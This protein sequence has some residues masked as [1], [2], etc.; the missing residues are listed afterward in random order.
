MKNDDVDKVVCELQKSPKISRHEL[1]VLCGHAVVNRQYMNAMRKVRGRKLP[2]KPVLLTATIILLTLLSGCVQSDVIYGNPNI[3]FE[4]VSNTTNLAPTI[5][6]EIPGTGE[7]VSGTTYWANSSAINLYVFAHASSAGDTA[8]VHVFIDGV[9]HED[10][11]GRPL[12]AAESSNKT[13]FAQ[14]PK[15]SNYSVWFYNYDHY[16]WREHQILSGRNGT[17]SINQ[18]VI[19]GTS[20]LDNA[21]VQ[22]NESQ[23]VNLV[24]DLNSKVNKSGDSMTGDL[25]VDLKNVTA[26]SFLHL[27]N[28]SIFS[29]YTSDWH[30][31]T[32][33][34]KNTNAMVMLTASSN[35]TY[36][37]NFFGG[38]RARGNISNPSA[39]CSGDVMF[40][41]YGIGHDGTVY[42]SANTNPN[43]I[44][45]VG[46]PAG[47]CWNVTSNPTE[48]TMQVTKLNTTTPRYRF[49]L[50]DS[51]NLTLSAYAGTGR[52]NACFDEN[53]A[54]VRSDLPC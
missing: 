2:V 21:S 29:A 17:L 20:S 26:N 15:G 3:A 41:F 39:V 24:S 54:I 27:A 51:G 7:R 48:I 8:E 4:I 47:A 25:D 46:G 1:V 11:S 9:K 44:F 36:S 53:G 18:T 35:F 37:T 28:K 43:I 38:V 16:E 42:K 45:R 5:H 34:E 6:A 10:T 33:S 13:A 32:Q 49:L 31:F 52:D 22:I 40:Y 14:I 30:Y 12:G 23:V 19:G 50:N